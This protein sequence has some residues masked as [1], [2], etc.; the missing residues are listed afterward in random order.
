MAVRLSVVVALV[1]HATPPPP[2]F[3]VRCVVRMGSRAAIAAGYV[4][5]ADFRKWSTFAHACAFPKS[6]TEATRIT[7][8]IMGKGIEPLRDVGSHRLARPPVSLRTTKPPLP[9]G[10]HQ[11]L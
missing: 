3:T 9:G 10:W 2:A 11:G 6:P 8:A 5:M 1:R 4:M 7:S